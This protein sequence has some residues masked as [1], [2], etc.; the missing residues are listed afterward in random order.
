MFPLKDRHISTLHAFF[1]IK[2][3]S[4]FNNTFLTLSES[5]PSYGCEKGKK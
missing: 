4:T 5:K 3:Y 1:I 2:L